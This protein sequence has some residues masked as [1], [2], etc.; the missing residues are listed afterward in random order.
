MTTPKPFSWDR[1][2]ARAGKFDGKFLIGVLTTG[3]Y[4]LPSCTARQPKPDNVRILRT[5]DEA[6]ALGLRACK[7]CRPDLFYRGEDEEIS[8]FEGLAARVRVAPHEFADAPGLAK[9][10]GVSLTKLGD[11]FRQHAHLA[12]AAWL[13]REHV[14]AA[15]RQLLQ[16]SDR[17]LEVGYAAGFESES[18][19]HRQFLALTRMT[20]G[21]YRAMNGASVF[22]LHLP[23]GYRAQEILA[24]HA[25]DPESPCERVDGNRILKALRTPQG[26]V[27]LELSLEAEGAWA[28]VYGV[29]KISR[30]TAAL[31]HASALR[32]L[33]LNNEVTAFETRMAKHE[34]FAPLV[35]KRKGLRVPAIPTG[36]DGLCW[37]IIGQ[38]VNVKFAAAL[39]REILNLAGEKIGDMRTHPTPEKVVDLGASRLAKLRYSRAK[40]EYLVGAARAVAE[41][42]LDIEGLPDTS[43]VAAEKKLTAIRGIG[44]WTAR[45]TMLRGGFAD[46]APAGDSALATVLQRVHKLDARPHAE[47]VE[48]LMQDFAP[49]RSLA[50]C[51]LWASYR[52]A[53]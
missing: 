20:P 49:H 7:R 44:K 9:A 1:A 41:G 6:K 3:I 29:D 13:R 28:R 40:A 27:A 23:G 34:G 42:S 31:L 24:Y 35:G 10:A 46:A 33:G 48:T 16:T 22:L 30:E 21:A 4:C 53:A 47:Q 32:M 8:L 26:P 2:E 18:V 37:A 38:Q 45:Y 43:A 12:P 14:R 11:L 25:R 15:A 39:R 52:D 17:V 19:F 36:F 5:E 50:T 51:H